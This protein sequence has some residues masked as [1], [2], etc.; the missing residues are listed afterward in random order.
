MRE[1]VY[2]LF[3][4]YPAANQSVDRLIGAGY[5]RNDI[6]VMTAANEAGVTW[7]NPNTAGEP[8]GGPDE[9]IERAAD[10]AAIGGVAGLLAG[11]AALALPGVGPLFV[12]GPVASVLA[13]TAAGTAAGAATGGLVGALEDAGV[14]RPKAVFLE[15][16]LRNGGVV[17]AVKTDRDDEA[18]RILDQAGAIAT[19]E[20]LHR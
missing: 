19:R 6:S 2:G 12:A 18:Q 16:G 11:V 3:R 14:D 10:G 15:E 7:S 4:D 8:S 13:S 5:N 1:N 17:V 20:E 9:T